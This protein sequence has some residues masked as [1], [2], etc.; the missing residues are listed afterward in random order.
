M[1]EL[2][3]EVL[4]CFVKL[5]QEAFPDGYFLKFTRYFLVSVDYKN[6]S[7]TLRIFLP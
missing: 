6:I 3:K 7:V 5:Y 2:A 4:G 1:A